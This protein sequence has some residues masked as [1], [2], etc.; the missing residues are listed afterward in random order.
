M[1]R[2]FKFALAGQFLTWAL[3][4]ASAQLPNCPLRPAPGSVVVDAP[5]LSSQNGSLQLALTLRNAVDSLGYTHY[6]FDYATPSGSLEAPT[7]RLN[8]GDT[9]TLD[10]TNHL[11]L[12]PSSYSAYSAKH[13]HMEG[14][15]S[16][17]ESPATDPCSSKLVNLNTT[18]LHFHGLNVPP[19]CHQDDVVNTLIQPSPT[20]FRYQ[21]QIPANEPPGLYWYHPHP[22]GFTTF[23]VNGGAT[24]AIIINGI[25]KIKPQVAGLTE[26]VLI[27]RQQFLDPGSW[28]PGPFQ[29]TLNFQ[30]AIFPGAASPV[31]QM[32]PGEKQFWRVAN[33]TTQAFLALQLLFGSTPQ[34]VE[35]ISLD[36]V[37]V[38][39]NPTMTTIDLAP[40]ARAEFIVTG[41]PAGTTATF[42]TA[43]FDTGPV[44]NA[45]AFHVLADVVPTATS[46]QA[47]PSVIPA[48]PVPPVTQRFSG[49]AAMKTTTQRKLYFSE[50]A[51]GTNPPVN[52]FITVDGQQP[53]LFTATE[54]PA[55]VT[56]VGAV[57][58][59][60]VEN[61]TSEEHAFH[62]H[63]IHFLVVAVDGKPLQNPTLQDTVN[64]PYWGGKGP[65][66]SVTLR[67]DFRD[68]NI[69][70][71]FV[72]HCHVLFHEDGGMMAK[73]RVDP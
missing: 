25:E 52:F 32:K 44:G 36:G 33:S 49:L 7:L 8:P 15:E 11:N 43:G 6:C 5:S 64:V 35:L 16:I 72:F 54:A 27:V 73:I 50:A 19:V 66:H 20:P 59:W 17:S 67:M 38:T 3:L 1:R 57:E 2:V 46:P 9:L 55:I 23:Q 40:A 12:P 30:P 47:R 31:I 13:A 41:P 14:M 24:G 71:T 56:K 34:P 21:I 60:T 48:A 65:F 18:N 26:R 29:F 10:L 68:P 42:V 69:A 62:M 37:P 70:G 51:V 45:N 63:Q 4:T 61:R 22:H 53:K 28:I 58:D 39:G